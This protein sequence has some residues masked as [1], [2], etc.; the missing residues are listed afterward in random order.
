[1]Q[2][3]THYCSSATLVLAMT[4]LAISVG[5]RLVQRAAM[6]R[7]LENWNFPELAE[8]LNRAGLQVRIQSPQKDGRL[9]HNAFL[10]TTS[11]DW[12]ALNRL[13]MNPGPRRIQEWRG[14]IYCE[15]AGKSEPS[16]HHWE[17]HLL[18]VGPFAFCGDAELL[19]RIRAI[20]APSAP[21]LGHG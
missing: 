12:V 7:A 9:A 20:L 6:R 18:V 8:H 15:R 10:T 3:F 14:I 19:E 11:K 1:M 2:R 13:G 17:D 5:Q 21:P 4:W 16:F